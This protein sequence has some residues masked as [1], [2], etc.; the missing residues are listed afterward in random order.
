MFLKKKSMNWRNSV[1][2]YFTRSACEWFNLVNRN[3]F[4]QQKS[5][6]PQRMALVFRFLVKNSKICTLATFSEVTKHSL[7]LKL[8]NSSSWRFYVIFE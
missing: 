2:L 1:M 7:W 6:R 8:I 3:I 4:T 5:K